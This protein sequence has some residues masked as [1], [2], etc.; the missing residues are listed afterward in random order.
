HSGHPEF[1]V[2]GKIFATLG[3]AGDW[4]MTRLPPKSQASFVDSNPDVFGP[5]AGAWGRQ[6]CTIIQLR[7]AKKAQVSLALRLAWEHTAPR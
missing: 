4:G 6:G 7:K 3:P 1:R 5:A 2:G